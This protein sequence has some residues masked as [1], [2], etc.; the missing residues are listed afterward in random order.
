MVYVLAALHRGLAR[1]NGEAVEL[2]FEVK[3]A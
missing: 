1:D 3:Q 2:D